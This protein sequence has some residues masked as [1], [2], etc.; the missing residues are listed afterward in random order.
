MRK[1]R[2]TRVKR[3]EKRKEKGQRQNTRAERDGESGRG[4]EK[5]TEIQS[6]GRVR[7]REGEWWVWEVIKDR[8]SSDLPPQRCQVRP[9]MRGQHRWAISGSILAA[10]AY[11]RPA[12]QS[13][14]RCVCRRWEG[15]GGEVHRAGIALSVKLMLSGKHTNGWLINASRP[16]SFLQSGT[17]TGEGGRRPVRHQGPIPQKALGVWQRFQNEE[18]IFLFFFYFADLYQVPVTLL[19]PFHISVKQH[20]VLIM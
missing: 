10:A 19:I 16:S 12:A 11:S 6:E 13:C 7:E 15:R 20:M 18:H 5:M 17:N 2:R 3:D 1:T 14:Q 9:G 4:K 8:N